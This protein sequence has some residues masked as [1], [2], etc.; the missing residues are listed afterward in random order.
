MSIT[1][2]DNVIKNNNIKIWIYWFFYWRFPARKGLVYIYA[3][4]LTL[5]FLL[6]S[7]LIS[8]HAPNVL[9]TSHSQCVHTRCH[10][11]KSPQIY[12]F[13][14]IL[15]LQE[16]RT[17]KLNLISHQLRNIATFSH[18]F[19]HIPCPL[20]VCLLNIFVYLF[21][22]WTRNESVVLPAPFNTSLNLFHRI[23]QIFLQNKRRKCERS[24]IP[25][26]LANVWTLWASFSPEHFQ[27][28]DMS[29]WPSGLISQKIFCQ[30]K[31]IN[32]PSKSCVSEVWQCRRS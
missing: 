16:F 10:H 18:K 13:C 8:C 11:Q 7:T 21:V 29:N 23:L 5:V 27:T 31:F 20:Y 22:L 24:Q 26:G 12:T 6:S 28:L 14:N 2:S 30:K 3:H 25:S 17:K 9:F 32:I 1:F 19:V 15:L 4:L